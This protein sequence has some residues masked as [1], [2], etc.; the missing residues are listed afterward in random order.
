MNNYAMSSGVYSVIGG[1]IGQRSASHAGITH[2]ASVRV[3]RHTNR[4]Y[5]G[6]LQNN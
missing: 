5:E 3:P 6:L 4:F 1:S 2:M